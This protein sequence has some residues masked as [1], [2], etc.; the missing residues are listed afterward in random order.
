MRLTPSAP[1]PP[2]PRG[3][4][5]C[6]VLTSD[7]RSPGNGRTS[8]GRR[9]PGSGGRIGA[10]GAASGAGSAR[11]GRRRQSSP[12]GPRPVGGGGGAVGARR[13]GGSPGLIS[14]LGLRGRVARQGRWRRTRLR[15]SARGA[16]AGRRTRLR[17]GPPGAEGYA[18]ARGA[19]SAGTLRTEG[20]TDGVSCALNVSFRR[21]SSA[22]AE[23]PSGP[24]RDG[25]LRTLGP[26]ALL[27]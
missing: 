18:P 8:R 5:R 1:H 27:A 25:A 21:G 14:A 26:G 10:G 2:P 15:V 23:A 7:A 12:G 4:K 24:R 16:A 19:V 13:S 17:P 9:E 20:E 3:G 11:G 22:P 6:S